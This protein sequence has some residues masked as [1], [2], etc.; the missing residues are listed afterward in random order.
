MQSKLKFEMAK[1]HLIH[2]S[3]DI[4]ILTETWLNKSVKLRENEG[5]FTVRT[6]NK[7]FHGVLANIKSDLQPKVWKKAGSSLIMFSIKQGN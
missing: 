5:F 3:P 2:H 4:A 7:D 6:K 1:A